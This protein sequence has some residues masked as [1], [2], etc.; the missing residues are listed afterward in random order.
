MSHFG[1][2]V[3]KLLLNPSPSDQDTVLLW[4]QYSVTM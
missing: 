2:N 4:M 1:R 3:Q